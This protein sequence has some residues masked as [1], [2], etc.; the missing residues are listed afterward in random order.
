MLAIGFGTEHNFPKT[1]PKSAFCDTGLLMIFAV[2]QGPRFLKLI[3]VPV[4]DI[5]VLP[6]RDVFFLCVDAHKQYKRE[7]VTANQCSL[8]RRNQ[9][10]QNAKKNYQF[11]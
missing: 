10:L 11:G 9:H 1:Y 7:D 5:I 4:F 3:F 2:Q 8:L 6:E